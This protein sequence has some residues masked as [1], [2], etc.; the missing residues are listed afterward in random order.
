[1]AD[2]TNDV[3]IR[4][5]LVFGKIDKPDLGPLKSGLG[6]ADD[7]AKKLK[8]DIDAANKALK[9]QEKISQQL[10]EQHKKAA[11]HAKAVADS[12]L[13]L[14]DA[15]MQMGEQAMRAARGIAFLTAAKE[16]D[17]K[18]A[19]EIIATAQ[20]LVDLY[21][22]S[23]G[24]IKGLVGMYR[25][26]AAAKALE[27]AAT[28]ANTTATHANTAAKVANLLLG[29]GGGL[30]RGAG[31]LVG[32]AGR[33]AMTGGRALLAGGVM[34]AGAVAGGVVYGGMKLAE[35]HYN[36]QSE[37]E[38]EKQAQMD[39]EIKRLDFQRSQRDQVDRNNADMEA[40]IRSTERAGMVTSGNRGGLAAAV[41]GLRG[42]RED[43]GGPGAA[44]RRFAELE[45][46]I[47][48]QMEAEKA[49][50][51]QVAE[52][53]K[54]QMTAEQ[55]SLKA[56][57]DRL[58]QLQDERKAIEDLRNTGTEAFGD[59][60][61]AAKLK[62][63]SAVETAKRGGTLDQA[64]INALKGFRGQEIEGAGKVDDLIKRSYQSRFGEQFGG[65]F[66]AG[67]DRKLSENTLDTNQTQTKIE[68]G[69]AELAKL[70]QQAKEQGEAIAK[71]IG[72]MMQEQ[73]DAILKRL[74]YE[75]REKNSSVTQAEYVPDGGG[76]T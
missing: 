16:E 46:A 13:R 22:G 72:D 60:D 27:T 10:E 19:M 42:G 38:L 43:E 1:M 3:T 65:L 17:L 53:Y 56:N 39:E 2:I 54:Q 50:G 51:Q 34:T 5:N 29:G 26:L 48:Q 12:H 67:L 21:S 20:G 9:E 66:G 32:G 61:A 15:S 40:S 45:D 4:A 35:R 6:D 63:E 18:R 23:I 28:V 64:Q 30:A 31:R 7:A 36:K 68:L 49:Y 8:A 14:A 74:Q 55:E 47:G 58:K 25:A 41:S 69:Q 44:S 71:A 75:T 37:A 70:R 57:Q 59:L 52:R 62:L 24:V 76:G 73:Q 33:A 11:E